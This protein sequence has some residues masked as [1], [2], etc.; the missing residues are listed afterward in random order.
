MF[1]IS[2]DHDKNGRLLVRAR[3]A[4]A[5]GRVVLLGDRQFGLDGDFGGRSIPAAVLDLLLEAL[6]EIKQHV[7]TPQIPDGSVL[8]ARCVTEDS[9]DPADDDDFDDEDSDPELAGVPRQLA[10]IA[11]T[12]EGGDGTPIATYTVYTNPR[13]PIGENP[14]DILERRG[15]RIVADRGLDKWNYRT[16]VVD[17][18]D[19][20]TGS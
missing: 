16:L 15:W 18:A 11:I 13:N 14:Y 3:S 20:R 9:V 17:R 12:V 5:E 7:T 4:H 6:Q 10:D 8:V 2:T 19:A 1:E